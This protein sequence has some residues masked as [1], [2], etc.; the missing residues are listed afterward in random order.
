MTTLF[1]V[2]LFVHNSLKS[3]IT[4]ESECRVFVFC[5]YNSDQFFERF[6]QLSTM[7]WVQ[8]SNS[9]LNFNSTVV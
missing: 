2:E 7:L 3:L 8:I 1:C 5:S 9:Y 4:Y 6:A